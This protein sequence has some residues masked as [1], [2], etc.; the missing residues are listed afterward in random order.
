MTSQAGY[1]YGEKAMA[2]VVLWSSGLFDTAAIAELLS[3]REDAVWR[4]LHETR[5]TARTAQ[6]RAATQ[7]GGAS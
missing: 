5:E 7:I 3:V 4:T 1:I 2:V 6:P